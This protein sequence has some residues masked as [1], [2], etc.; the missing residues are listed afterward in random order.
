LKRKKYKTHI[1]Y[2]VQY[3]KHYRRKHLKST[4]KQHKKTDLIKC[5]SS[6]TIQQSQH[7]TVVLQAF[8]NSWFWY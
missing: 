3:L 6:K 1:F 8:F 7:Y 2:S 5:L 4:F